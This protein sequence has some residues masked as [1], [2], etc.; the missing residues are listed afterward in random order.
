[1]ACNNE[2]VPIYGLE[3]TSSPTIGGTSVM[4]GFDFGV[5]CGPINNTPPS[6]ETGRALPMWRARTGTLLTLAHLDLWWTRP[7][8]HP[9][10]THVNPRNDRRNRDMAFE[11]LATGIVTDRCNGLGCRPA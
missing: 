8:H 2:T 9:T 1:M 10:D 11:F 5:P 7:H 6:V 4:V 3:V